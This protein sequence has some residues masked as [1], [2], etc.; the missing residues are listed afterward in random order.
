MYRG[1]KEYFNRFGLSGDL[2]SNLFLFLKGVR[3][4]ARESKLS[5]EMI[6]IGIS[7]HYKIRKQFIPEWT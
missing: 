3:V 1:L 5:E 6:K 2:I 7:F 4:F